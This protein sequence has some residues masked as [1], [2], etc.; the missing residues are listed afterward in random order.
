MCTNIELNEVQTVLLEQSDVRQR[1]MVRKSDENTRRCI[2]SERRH[3][4]C[5][6]AK[7]LLHML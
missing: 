2:L 6:F 4:P 5:M 7:A 3:V 1:K